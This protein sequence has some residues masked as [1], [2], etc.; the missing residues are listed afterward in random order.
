VD[1]R[2]DVQA[3][4]EKFHELLQQDGDWAGN[5]DVAET[6]VV[7]CDD[8]TMTVRLTCGGKNPGAAWRLSCR[9]REQIIAWLQQV[10][11]GRYLP[12]RRVLLQD[13]NEDGEPTGAKQ[14]DPAV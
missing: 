13:G 10:E 12:R 9:L 3:I 2:A 6:L 1:Y 5:R 14:A 8:Q 7:A 4:R 11:G